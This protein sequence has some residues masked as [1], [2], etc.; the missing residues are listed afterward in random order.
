MI[1]NFLNLQ[2]F[3][4]GTAK[5]VSVSATEDASGGS[6]KFTF[7]IIDQVKTVT[8]NFRANQTQTVRVNH[9]ASGKGE[10]KVEAK[11]SSQ[12]LTEILDVDKN[13][14]DDGSG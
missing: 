10:V 7:T 2:S 9:T 5:S 14:G 1:S 13:P 11:N 6:E 4:D 12:S 3:N 8:V